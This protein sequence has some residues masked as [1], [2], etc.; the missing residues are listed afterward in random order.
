L[1]VVVI[2]GQSRPMIWRCVVNLVE[3]GV[4]HARN[5]FTLI[6]TI[7][8]F[9][10]DSSSSGL[11]MPLMKPKANGGR[12]GG[13][14]EEEEEGEGVGTATAVDHGHALEAVDLLVRMADVFVHDVNDDDAAGGGGVQ[15]QGQGMQQRR[16]DNNRAGV[17]TMATTVEYVSPPQ[18][19]PH[20]G[21]YVV[22]SRHSTDHHHPD[23][24]NGIQQ[25]QQPMHQQQQGQEQEQ[26]QRDPDR[27]TCWLMILV[28]LRELLDTPNPGIQARVSSALQRMLFSPPDVIAP[29]KL[30]EAFDQVLFPLLAPA[31]DNNHSSN[32]NNS[33]SKSSKSSGSQRQRLGDELRLRAVSL[34]AGAFLHNVARLSKLPGFHLLWLRMV[35]LIAAL[36]K[37]QPRDSSSSSSSRASASSDTAAVDHHVRETTVETLKNLI[38]VMQGEGTL[39]RLSKDAG[40]NVWQLTWDVID[41]CSRDA[42]HAIQSAIPSPSP[43][44]TDANINANAN[45]NTSR[46]KESTHEPSAEF[47]AE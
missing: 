46:P 39:D 2:A 26:Y 21:M 9:V 1:F 35:S 47:A 12:Q 43:S 16:W 4:V 29:E 24:S 37:Q 36:L 10:D 31:D 45:T 25:Q 3:A 33:S 42:R 22:S 13:G 32:N 14:E 11:Y 20:L 18:S 7:A 30:V 27:D 38:M 41:S 5:V 28:Q 23:S 34:V 17:N 19:P 15:G 8:L 6:S 44:A 40:A